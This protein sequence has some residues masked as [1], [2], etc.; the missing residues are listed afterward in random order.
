METLIMYL[1]TKEQLIALKAVAK[2]LK[3]K[4]EVQ[5]G[6]YDPEFVSMIKDAEQRGN[7]KDVNPDDLWGSLN[8]K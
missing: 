5:G 3:I 7:F 4:V 6:F 8:L 1:K 2:A